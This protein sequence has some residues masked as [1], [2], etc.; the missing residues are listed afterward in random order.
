MGKLLKQ[1]S[2]FNMQEAWN[3]VLR[4]P[5]HIVIW[6]SKLLGN[7][8]TTCLGAITHYGTPNTLSFC[9]DYRATELCSKPRLLKMAWSFSPKKEQ[10]LLF[11]QW[12]RIGQPIQ[13][14]GLVLC[15]AQNCMGFALWKLSI[16][17]TCFATQYVNRASN[18][19]VENFESTTLAVGT[20][21][22]PHCKG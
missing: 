12:T 20:P 11:G 6:N 8:C 14:I 22:F 17:K 13:T 5:S 3:V 10:K 19:T 4:I 1:L 2:T 18:W 9:R 15:D 16:R 7:R 21:P